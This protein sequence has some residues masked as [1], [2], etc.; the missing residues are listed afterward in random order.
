M[1]N[2]GHL[3]KK[4]PSKGTFRGTFEKKLQHI[5][6]YAAGTSAGIVSAAPFHTLRRRR[7]GWPTLKIDKTCLKIG[8]IF[9]GRGLACV[10]SG[11]FLLPLQPKFAN[12]IMLRRALI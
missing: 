1:I 3:S 2:N 10:I 5:R 12:V 7:M 11:G 8:K 9:R 4:T 6:I